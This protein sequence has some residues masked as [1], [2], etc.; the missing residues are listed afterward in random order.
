MIDNDFSPALKEA[1][2][3]VRLNKAAPD[4]LA[5][6]RL[7]VRYWDIHDPNRGVLIEEAVMRAR[8][9]IAKAT[10]PPHG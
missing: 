7:V 4:L 3:I 2:A 10:E 6:A 5:V 1:A 9:A 8:A